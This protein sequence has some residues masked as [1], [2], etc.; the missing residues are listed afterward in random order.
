[1]TIHTVA[2]GET[3]TGIAAGYGVS[4]PRLIADN[5]L[6]PTLTLVPGQTLVILYP[7]EIYLTEPGDTLES[8][9]ARFGTTRNGLLRNNP[10]LKGDPEV[11]PGDELVLSFTDRRQGPVTVNGYAYPFIDPALL[12][13]TLPYLSD[14]GVFS[15]GFEEDGSLVVPRDGPLLAVARDY[16]IPP[17]LVFTTLSRAGTF[18]S[19]LA[20]VLF[21]D[22]AL[23]ETVI[24]RL[25]AVMEEKGYAGIDVD[26][27]FVPKGSGPE[28]VAFVE[29]LADRTRAAG[30]FTAVALAPKTSAE[31]PGLL[32]EGHDYA[33]LGAAADRVLLMTYEWGYTYGPPLA[34]APLPSVRRVIEFGVS[35]IPRD[36]ILMGI[37]N[38]GYDWPLPYERGVTVARSVG[39]EEAVDIARRYRA[40][41]RFDEYA[42]A[43]FF[44]YTDGAGTGHEV[45]F[46]DARSIRD[47]LAL[48][49]EYGLLGAGYWTVM[50]PF[51]GNWTVLNALYE[52]RQ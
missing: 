15:Y 7:E 33:G 51:P 3:L 49:P 24:R 20:G 48:I 14:L 13:Y 29:R 2:A 8:I 43:P 42:R 37:P 1:M 38:Y 25:I 22:M 50:R 45:W 23:Q 26:F 41:I 44:T 30:K 35:Q 52:L 18:R 34:V 32:Y 19:E 6:D 4:L 11:I 28:F 17:V 31:Q 47:K 40:E 46:E 21:R 39:N 9:A 27:E 10:Q 12:R 36:K 16:G 5:G